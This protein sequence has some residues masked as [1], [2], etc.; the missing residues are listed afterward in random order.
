MTETELD[1]AII[2]LPGVSKRY[3]FNGDGY[4]VHARLFA[5]IEPGV[6]G[7]ARNQAGIVM[8]IPE[9]QRSAALERE[10]ART[11]T[12]P[13]TSIRHDWIFVP[14]G[15]SGEDAD[16]EVLTWAALAREHVA[17]M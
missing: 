14:F 7:E 4:Y 9:P 5:F 8:R 15:P 11:F 16:E 2:A 3:A 1:A 10:G 13:R 12:L 6:P 17:A